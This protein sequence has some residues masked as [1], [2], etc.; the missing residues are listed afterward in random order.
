MTS[1]MKSKSNEKNLPQKAYAKQRDI[2]MRRKK[3]PGK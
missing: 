2:Q 3:M 1:T